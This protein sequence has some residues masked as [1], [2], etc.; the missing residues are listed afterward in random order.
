M[1][2]PDSAKPDYSRLREGLC[3]RHGTPLERRDDHGWCDECSVGWSMTSDTTSV[4]LDIRAR[5][6][7]DVM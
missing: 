7:R 4:Y 1:S 3:P 6:K 2:T 5:R